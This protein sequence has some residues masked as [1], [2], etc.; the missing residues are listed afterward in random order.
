MITGFA[1]GGVCGLAGGVADEFVPVAG[2]TVFFGATGGGDALGAD[3]VGFGADEGAGG[4]TEASFTPKGDS[5]ACVSSVVS[6]SLPASF[7]S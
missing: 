4:I 3:G 6:S 2:G 1:A 7:L 5:M